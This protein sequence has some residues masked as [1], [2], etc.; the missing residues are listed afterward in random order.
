MNVDPK[1]KKKINLLGIDEDTTEKLH[2]ILDEPFS[3]SSPP[4]SD[5][6]SDDEDINIDYES[7]SYQLVVKPF[8][9]K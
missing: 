4:S 3:D 8:I 6:Y 7:D 5:E 1:P 9:M 2:S